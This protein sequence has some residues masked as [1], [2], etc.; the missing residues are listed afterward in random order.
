M[1]AEDFKNKYLKLRESEYIP[2]SVRDLIEMMIRKIFRQEGKDESGQI[3]N[4]ESSDTP[5][6]H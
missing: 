6:E 3:L 1:S 2:Q 5:S 4:K